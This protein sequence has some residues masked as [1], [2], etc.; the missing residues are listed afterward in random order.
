MSHEGWT[1][2]QSDRFVMDTYACIRRE[3]FPPALKSH[4]HYQSKFSQGIL[5]LSCVLESGEL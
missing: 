5:N 1:I 3:R 2:V 4:C